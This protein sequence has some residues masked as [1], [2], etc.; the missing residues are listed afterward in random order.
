M[1]DNRDKLIPAQ[2][3]GWTWD[4]TAY[5]AKVPFSSADDLTCAKSGA[6]FS[7][8]RNRRKWS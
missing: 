7:L 1:E 5:A 4:L 2:L 6:S 8:T 3:A